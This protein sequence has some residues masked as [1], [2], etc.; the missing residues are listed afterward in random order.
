MRFDWK[1][2]FYVLNSLKLF[3]TTQTH[4]Y[5]CFIDLPLVIQAELY[6]L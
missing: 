5:E 3:Q 4:S 1:R 2:I 6:F